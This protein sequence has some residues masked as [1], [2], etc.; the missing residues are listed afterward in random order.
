MSNKLP[1]PSTAEGAILDIF[2]APNI[3]LF[4]ETQTPERTQGPYGINFGSKTG[5]QWESTPLSFTSG[6][7]YLPHLQKTT[8]LR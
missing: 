6:R 4:K 1:N 8:P 3:F 2:H 7:Q 5:G